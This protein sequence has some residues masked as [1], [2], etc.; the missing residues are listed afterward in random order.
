MSKRDVQE[1]KIED[2]ILAKGERHWKTY[3]EQLEGL[4][5]SPLASIRPI[6]SFDHYALGEQLEVF[7]QMVEFS[8]AAG[9]ISDLG[10]LPNIGLDVIGIGYG[11]SPAAMVASIQP[12]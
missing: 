1:K 9:S 3:R 6:S 7:E 5:D 2:K 8:E 11:A 10:T 4:E 12:V